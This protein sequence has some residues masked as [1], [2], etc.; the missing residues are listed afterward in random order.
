MFSADPA[1]Y[2]GKRKSLTSSATKSL[3]KISIKCNN[4]FICFF[5][6]KENLLIFELIVNLFDFEVILRR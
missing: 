2:Q 4:Q 6:N 5:L 3:L 1:S